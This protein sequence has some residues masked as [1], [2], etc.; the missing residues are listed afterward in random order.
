MD[1]LPKVFRTEGDM[2]DFDPTKI[3]ISIM[4]ETGMS[5][6]NA[7]HIT[8]LVVRR[9]ISTNM[10][11]LS[12]P[13][14]REIVC[15]V[16]SEQ[17]FEQERKY[18]T[19]IGMPLMDYE[20]ILEKGPAN[21]IEGEMINPEK[22]H[23]WASNQIAEE[24]ALLRILSNEESKAHLYGD[25]FIHEL[26]YF[27]L[28]PLSQSW[29]PR[30]ILKYGLPPV[31]S[32]T[33]CCKS[34]PA[35]DLRVA[36]NHLVKWI[37]M[38]G[39]EFSGNQGLNFISTFLAP[40]AKGLSGVVIKHHV[41]GLIYEINQL[42]AIIGR[43]IPVT[44]ISCCPQILPI[45]SKMPAIGPHGII[46]G[47]YGD[48]D[49]E[50]LSIFNAITEIFKEGD[51]YKDAFNSP[52]HFIYFNDKWLSEH[53]KAYL[54]IWEEVKTMKTP[55]LID[56]NSKWFENQIL[57]QISEKKIIN[58]GT[59]Q[60][61]YLNLPRFAYMSNN[62]SDFLY[63]IKE[64]M[65]LSAGILIKKFDIIKKRLSTNHLPISNAVLEEG[66][67]FEL[68]RQD[69]SIG[70]VGL[71]EAVKTLTNNELHENP[72]S[73]NLGIKIIKEMSDIC[74]EM[75]NRDNKKYSLN[76]IP[77]ESINYRF[78]RLDLKHFPGV[79]SHHLNEKRNYYTSSAHY[80]DNV[81]IESIEDIFKLGK[82]HQL[83][84]NG[85]IE[86]ISL[87]TLKRNEIELNDFI[88]KLCEKTEITS[89]KFVE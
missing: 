44:S 60:H 88:S 1:L 68:E 71:N 67:I 83:I 6:Q 35:G 59:L 34:G 56:T 29:D 54:N 9:I 36:I 64:M 10:K 75:S 11:F 63:L 79:A 57:T 41:Q 32:W 62:E 48:Y 28:R 55:Y 2:V 8:E 65:D 33:H 17:H 52:K 27:D 46:N 15:S 43:E 42:S 89:V 77:S 12:G 30:F 51:F 82:F 38:T 53:E 5:E 45:L 81:A 66:A 22:I 49:L 37:G 24:Y 50:C 70:V 47:V 26:K 14:I 78:A 16:L 7:N 18:Y 13:H 31:D 76:E 20:E 69:L 74:G 3:M 61:I 19:R 85:I 21:M 87:D 39:G 25:I 23:H 80:R 86:S 58:F 72:D 40:Y 84:Q 4:K 73:L